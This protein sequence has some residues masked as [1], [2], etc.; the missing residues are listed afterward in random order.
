MTKYNKDILFIMNKSDLLDT[1]IEID[2]QKE[3]IEKE[4][5]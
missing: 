3:T 2:E 1:D 5:K 4:I